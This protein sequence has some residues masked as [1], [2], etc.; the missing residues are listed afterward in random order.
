MPEN[1]GEPAEFILSLKER[2]NMLVFYE[3]Q[4]YIKSLEIFFFKSW[5]DSGK[6]GLHF[7]S[8]SKAETDNDLVSAGID[9]ESFKKR[10]LLKIFS[11]TTL[12]LKQIKDI[13]EDFVKNAQKLGCSA[14]IIIH[15]Q[16]LSLE[17]YHSLESLEDFL[18][19]IYQKYD[20]SIL[21]SYNVETISD[22]KFMQ[23]LIR[24]H[25]HVIFA[26]SFGNGIVIKTK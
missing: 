17:Q 6:A 18:S 9:V 11:T 26:P 3:D 7:S 16:D 13:I 24:M 21:D 4:E 22:A 10:N 8:Q 20:I 15:H 5:L 19:T 1:Q 25:D 2:A 14:R 12:K 23:Q